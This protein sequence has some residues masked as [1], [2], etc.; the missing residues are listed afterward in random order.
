[1]T[2]EKKKLCL[3]FLLSSLSWRGLFLYIMSFSVHKSE[4]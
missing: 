2:K 4:P 3:Q 1:L